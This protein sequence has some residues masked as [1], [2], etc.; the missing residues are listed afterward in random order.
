MFNLNLLVL[1]TTTDG[2]DMHVFPQKTYG[3][4]DQQHL[5]LSV[6]FNC[7]IYHPIAPGHQEETSLNAQQQNPVSS[8][9]GCLKMNFVSVCARE[10]GGEQTRLIVYLRKIQP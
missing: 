8:T 4:I 9:E 3:D 10:I 1:C 6:L 5:S 7:S 2:L